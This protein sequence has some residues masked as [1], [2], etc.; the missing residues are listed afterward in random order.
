MC[1]DGSRLVNPFCECLSHQL[2]GGFVNNAFDDD[3]AFLTVL[4]Q[5]MG[6][7]KTMC[8]VKKPLRKTHPLLA[9]DVILFHRFQTCQLSGHLGRCTQAGVIDASTS[10]LST[11]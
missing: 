9:C 5:L 1:G 4:F 7:Q 8:H 10:S 6:R 2:A 3:V 11:R